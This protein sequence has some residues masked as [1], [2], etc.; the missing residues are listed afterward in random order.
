VSGKSIE[1]DSL[2]GFSAA[3]ALL[4]V[5]F[6]VSMVQLRN[7]REAAQWV[8]HTYE[9][10]SE[11]ESL[12]S[13]L[14]AAEAAR[15]GFL[16]TGESLYL[17]ERGAALSKLHTHLLAARM[18]TVDNP[19]QQRALRELDAILVRRAAQSDDLIILAQ[20]ESLERAQ[21][22]FSSQAI[23]LST[24]EA[25]NKIADL[26]A[27]EHGLLRTRQLANDRYASRLTLVFAIMLLAVGAVGTWLC[28][29]IRHEMLH[30][31]VAN[32]ELARVNSGLQAANRELESFSYSISHDLRSPLRA[33]DGYSLMLQEDFG[34]QLDETAQRYIKTI[35]AGSQRMATLIDDLLSF[36]RLSRQNLNRQAVDMTA[37]ARRAAAEVLEGQPEPKPAVEIG[38]LPPALGDPALLRQVWTNLIGNAVKY[39]SKSTTPEVHV[40]AALESD[41]VRYEVQD[42]G[43]GFDM[44]YADK[45]FGVFQRLHTL[46]EYPG[47]GVGLA[48]VQRIISRHH[49]AVTAHGERG[50]GAT[51]GFTLPVE[52]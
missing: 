13:A 52:G 23:H 38:E 47:T 22:A 24:V 12:S 48:I 16:A 45:L 51:F 41:R 42:N 6:A 37:L 31:R 49:G 30:R 36:S 19:F 9:V 7:S 11:L 18:L 40:R 44:K 39:S 3:A 29:S 1:R 21:R 43:V 27:T 10:I 2:I 25:V 15:R 32:D 8:T 17:D 5:I 20:T 26:E 34:P 33:I 28:L 4:V 46:E 14:N 50:K 35:R